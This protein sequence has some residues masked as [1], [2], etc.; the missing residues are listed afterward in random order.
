M[1]MND[2]EKIRLW[3]RD[4][5]E[6]DY[7]FSDTDLQELLEGEGSPEGAVALGWLLTAAEMGE[8]AVSESIGNTSESYAQPTEKY[9]VAMAMHHYWK[10]QDPNANAHKGGLWWEIRPDWAEGTGGIVAELLE[11]REFILTNYN[12]SSG[13]PLP[14]F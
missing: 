1:A 14:V 7:R 12:P 13:D 11:H 2:L 6:A 10:S 4:Q 3:L 9:K 8:E 5:D